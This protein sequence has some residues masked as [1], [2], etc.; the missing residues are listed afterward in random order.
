[1]TGPGCLPFRH[2]RGCACS[3]LRQA[4]P[5]CRRIGP[6]TS[7]YQ[8]RFWV[9]AQQRNVNSQLLRR[10]I[11]LGSMAARH[12]SPS[13][14]ER[15]FERKVRL[16]QWALQFERLWPRAWMLLGLAGLF[17]AVSMAGLWPLLPELPHK[18]VLALF[19]LAFL[20]A[21]VA[22]VRVRSPSREEAIR[23]V[24]G[25][26]GIKHRPASS[27]ED[28]LTLGAEDARTAALWRVH[29]TRL[30]EMLKKLRV[31]RPE[32]RTDRMDPYAL[33]ALLL[34][35]VFVLTIV[36]GDSASDRLAAAFRF[37]PL[38]KGADARLD[39]WITPPAYTGKAP[40][41]LAD[42][43]YHHYGPNARAAD[44]PAGPHEVPDRSVLIVRSSG[45]GALTLEVVGSDSQPADKLEAPTP[46][47]VSD[48][49]E[50]KHEV[51]RS[52]TVIAKL[53]GT[54][55][56]SWPFQVIPD[57]APKISITKEPERTPRGGL[58][59][60][61]KVEDDYGVASA[62]T[63]IRR[64]A[65]KQDTSR[66]AWA[67]VETKK[68]ARPPYER[69]PALA[70]RLPRS[71]PKAAEGTSF[72]EIGDHPWAGMKVQLTLVA[73][74]LAGQTGR[75]ETIELVLPERRFTKP[76]ARAVVEQRRKLV[77]DP[78]DRLQV[79]RALEALTLEPEQFIEDLQVYLGLRSVF[80]RLQ[81]PTTRADPQQRHRPAVERG[82]AHRGRQPLGCR[83]C[84]EG[85][86]GA[87]VESHRGGRIRRGDPAPD[88]GAAA[89]I[90]AVP[91]PA[92]Q[93]GR[94][95][96]AAA[97]GHQPQPDDDAAR[98]RSDA[99][100]S[101][102]HGALGQPR[103]GPADAEPAARPAGS[104]AVGPHGRPGPE[105]AH[106]PDDGRVR[107][108]HLAPATAARRH[109]R[110]AAWSAG[111]A[112]AARPTGTARPAGS[113]WPTGS[114]RPARPGPA[115]PSGRGRG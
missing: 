76:L 71:Y 23:R 7:L 22:L 14:L 31:G 13:A 33:R 68:G 36:V 53:G 9:F 26:S 38:A 111:P 107:Q 40:L 35:S 39:A 50:L 44:R 98:S 65:P 27:Y 58:K 11:E 91:R 109:V 59:F 2:P 61:F 49:S 84:A 69:P 73:K 29:R 70:L 34:L 46:A 56:G 80:Y 62:E 104:S 43:A 60:A 97:A 15:T 24:E 30:A 48:V 42:G 113:A 6:A 78:R 67:R 82:A 106:G 19:G 72:H 93:A 28:T 64:M 20:A 54:T 103:H 75:S 108:H 51:R 87:P 8:Q 77:E 112:R 83:A 102:E 41:M 99:E 21:L 74:D 95:P 5:P 85:R 63:R 55:V 96:A 25:V 89:G 88:A 12:T 86:P 45:G 32:P 92:A 90:G 101:R 81:Q 16:S 105:P 10:M 4:M 1:M 66:T 47:N 37:G 3:S 114:A 110:P 57:L 100:E 52:G 79:A 115:G 94:G 17:I 18:I